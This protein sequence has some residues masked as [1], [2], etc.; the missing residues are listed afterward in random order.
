MA[1]WKDSRRMSFN[2]VEEDMSGNRKAWGFSEFEVDHKSDGTTLFTLRDGYNNEGRKVTLSIH[3]CQDGAK[4]IALLANP[5]TAERQERERKRMEQ[6]RQECARARAAGELPV[7]D[8]RDK[9]SFACVYDNCPRGCHTLRACPTA[10]SECTGCKNLIANDCPNGGVVMGRD[11]L[12][13]RIAEA[14]AG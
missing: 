4:A 7:G 9:T 1:V 11:E 10:L 6:R 12:D 3:S 5:R 13:K 8:V 14:L 2:V